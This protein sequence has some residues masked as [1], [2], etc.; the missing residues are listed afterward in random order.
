MKEKEVKVYPDKLKIVSLVILVEM[1]VILFG[2]R[3][4]YFPI[5]LTAISILLMFIISDIFRPKLIMNKDGIFIRWC[6]FINWSEIKNIDVSYF[7]FHPY[8]GE[9]FESHTGGSRPVLKILLKQP[10]ETI[11]K[12]SIFSKISLYISMVFTSEPKIRID[13]F[14]LSMSALDIWEIIADNYFDPLAEKLRRLKQIKDN[15]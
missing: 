11:K 8:D 10:E 3:Y 9:L 5:L 2:R 14:F 7:G 12:L 13:T 6:G 4:S 1:V 15:K